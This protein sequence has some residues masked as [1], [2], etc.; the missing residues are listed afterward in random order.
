ME[1]AR[2]FVA[3]IVGFLTGCASI[4]SGTQHTVRVTTDPPGALVKLDGTTRALSPAVLRPSARTAHTVTIERAGYAPVTAMVH[5]HVSG[6]FFANLLNGFLPG[7]A[8][9]Y[10]TGAV[11]TLEPRSIDARLSPLRRR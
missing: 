7:A 11:Y 4:F 9:D 3:V 5:R 6:W 2:L 1:V 8:I 10:A